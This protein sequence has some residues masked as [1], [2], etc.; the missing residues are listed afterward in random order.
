MSKLIYFL[1]QNRESRVFQVH[2]LGTN[3]NS[4]PEMIFTGGIIRP[5]K[6]SVWGIERI[7]SQDIKYD[8]SK[9]SQNSENFPLELLY[10][11]YQNMLSAAKKINA[12]YILQNKCIKIINMYDDKATFDSTV[13]FYIKKDLS[14]K[15]FEIEQE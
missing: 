7:I 14:D 8:P 15:D 6:L 13:L 4:K 3:N 2:H 12:D 11:H 9:F 1:N 10:E 5:E